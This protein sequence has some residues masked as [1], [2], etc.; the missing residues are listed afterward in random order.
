M[1]RTRLFVSTMVSGPYARS[2][3]GTGSHSWRAGFSTMSKPYIDNP[4]VIA[5]YRERKIGKNMLLFGNYVDAD[6]NSRSNTRNMFDG[7]LL[8]HGDLLVSQ[9]VQGFA[10]AVGMCPRLHVPYPWHRLGS[11]RAADRYDGTPD[12]P[13]VHESQ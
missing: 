4:N 12:E 2:A 13:A 8:I 6:A 7:D 11:D 1:A 5:R 10:D 9:R 3:D